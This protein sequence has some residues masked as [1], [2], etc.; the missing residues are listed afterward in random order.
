[1]IP[2]PSPMAV[3]CARFRALRL[4]DVLSRN[5]PRGPFTIPDDLIGQELV[6]AG[7]VARIC[8]AAGGVIYKLSLAGRRWRA[9]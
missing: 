9:A 3:A 2:V 1:M 6:D 5:P 8:H 7:W 4:M